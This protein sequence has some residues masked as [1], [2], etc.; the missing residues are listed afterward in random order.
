MNLASNIVVGDG[1]RCQRCWH[2]TTLTFSEMKK[3]VSKFFP[4]RV[5]LHLEM[6]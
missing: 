3:I 4:D 6:S 2:T 1:L 5:D